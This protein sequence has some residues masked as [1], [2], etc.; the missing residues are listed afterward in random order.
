MPY[1]ITAANA[2]FILTIPG[3][4]SSGRQLQEFAV[5]DAFTTEAVDADET[6][7]GVDGYGVSGYL[8]RAPMMTI[9]F[10][11]SARANPEVFENWIAAQD[12]QQDVIF[13]SAVIVMPSVARKYTCYRGSLARA[14]SMADV[15]RVLSP[16]EFG[17]RWLPTG[18]QPAISMSPA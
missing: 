1:S 15:R 16:R 8:P 18:Q 4:Y 6:Q 5:D 13:A 9:R 10:L 3:V 17:I 2:V 11:A 12:N 7:V 14:S